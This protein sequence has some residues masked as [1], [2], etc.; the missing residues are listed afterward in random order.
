MCC[1]FF[2]FSNN[3]SSVISTNQLK[4]PIIYCMLTVG[5]KSILSEIMHSGCIVW[6]RTMLGEG[7]DSLVFGFKLQCS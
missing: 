1:V 3:P 5:L 6:I 7:K 2:S 4:Y